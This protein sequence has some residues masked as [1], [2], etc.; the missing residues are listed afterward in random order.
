MAAESRPT[1]GRK[2][3]MVSGLSFAFVIEAVVIIPGSEASMLVLMV[4][5]ISHGVF[6]SVYRAITQTI[7]GFTAAG[8][9]M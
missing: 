4:A 3:Y 7:A 6:A 8:I 5:C 9:W 2:T 1:W